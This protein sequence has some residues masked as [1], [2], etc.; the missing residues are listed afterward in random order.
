MKPQ[1]EL[2]VIVCT[3]N[4][5]KQ[6]ATLIQCLGSQKNIEK[7]SSKYKRA[8]AISLLRRSMIRKMPYS[9]FNINW[10][11]I[12]QLRD[13]EYSYK[14]YKRKRAYHNQSFKYHF[15]DNLKEY[16]DAV[17]DNKQENVAYNEDVFNM[18]SIHLSP[19]RIKC[20][21]LGLDTLKNAILIHER[22][23]EKNE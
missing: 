20:A 19:I 10:E 11:K 2:S 8:I 12:K 15:L 9:R 3:R 4:R 7:L 22:Y 13:E 1:V 6:L 21:L 23:G 5:A 14:N 18:L 16:N 17:F